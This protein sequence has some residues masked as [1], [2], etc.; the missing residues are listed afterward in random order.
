MKT[1]K[2]GAS[3]EFGWSVPL[4]RELIR[5]RDPA[6]VVKRIVAEMPEDPE[7]WLAWGNPSVQA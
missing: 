3:G 7:G 6:A 4:L 5:D 2:A 1:S